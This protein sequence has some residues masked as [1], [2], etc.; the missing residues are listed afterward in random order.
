[1]WEI[2]KKDLRKIRS[3]NQPLRIE[4]LSENAQKRKERVGFA[5]LSLRSAKV[6]T[7][8]ENTPLLWQKFIGVHDKKCCQPELSIS[9]TIQ[10]HVMQRSNFNPDETG[11]INLNII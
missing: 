11:I 4:C 3:T 2:E 1:M 9:L 8:Q 7:S 6:V 5:L 10:E